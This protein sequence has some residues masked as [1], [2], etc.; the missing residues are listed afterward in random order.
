MIYNRL[1]AYTIDML[2]IIILT[3]L[4]SNTTALNPYLY[5][6][7]DAYNKYQE[8]YNKMDFSGSNE[9]AIKQ[10]AAIEEPMYNLEKT[11]MYELIWYLGLSVFYFVIFQALN[12]GQTIGKKI[13]KI[14][15]V[16]KDGSDV[17]VIRLLL[18]TIFVGSTFYY[19]FNLT[20]LL[21]VIA[22]S[23]LNMHAYLLVYF[24]ITFLALGL[25]FA[26]YIVAFVRRDKGLLNDMI[27]GVKTVDLKNNVI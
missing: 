25:E 2:L 5:D 15:V 20:T 21:N 18:H 1:C 26:Y 8:V 13:C 24:L 14:K 10:L 7:E 27:A 19:G 4:V 6:R 17:G 12:K 3:Y 23:V 22:L 11:Q 16:K 9:D